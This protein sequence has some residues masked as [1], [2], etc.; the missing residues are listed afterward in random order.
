MSHAPL[1][2]ILRSRRV[3]VSLSL[4]AALLPVIGCG[5]GSTDE[6]DG[7]ASRDDAVNGPDLGVDYAWA[8]PAP[9][10]LHAE[11]YRFVARYLSYDTTG[12]NLSKGEAD[13]LIKAGLDI[14]SDWEWGAEDSLQGYDL[15]VTEAKAAEAQAKADGMPDGRPIYFSIDFDAQPDQQA[16]I[17]AYYEGVASVL[18]LDRTGAYGGYG[19]IS[20]LFDDGKI[21]WGWQTYA[22]SDGEWD[23]RAQLRQFQN[24]IGPGGGEDEDRSMVADFGQW[25]ISTP[26]PTPKPTPTPAPKP[27][28][29]I[30]G[31]ATGSNVGVNA[32]GRLEVFARGTDNALFHAWQKTA[33][34]AWSDWSSLGGDLTNAAEIGVNKDGRLEVFARGTNGALFH[35]WQ[36]TAGG[37]WSGWSSLGGAITGNTAVGVNADGRLEVFAR[38]TDDALHHVW[39]TTAGGAW[40]SWAKL[41]GDITG[42][43]GLGVNHDGRLEAFVRDS[44]GAVSHIWQTTPN[45][46]W[47]GFSSLGGDT[48]E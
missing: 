6:S 11:G 18:G 43:A 25:P 24:G 9:S 33:G 19:P 40:S 26:A 4:L 45:G 20:R 39:Q 7:V 12:K 8:R 38:G 15:G 27:T 14:V 37:A 17:N 5:T 35:T 22:W 44:S 34:G 36:T 2:R 48:L 21:K 31:D 1:A 28:P 13:E 46:G 30:A 10:S 29:S 3:L 16:A 42:Q 23:S 47:S 32:D 41:G